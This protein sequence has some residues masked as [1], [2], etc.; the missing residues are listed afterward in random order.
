MADISDIAI[1]G[2]GPVG[3]ALALALR[4]SGLKVSLL[5]ARNAAEIN[6][7]PRA[8][9]LS[10]GSRLLLM[11]LGVWDALPDVSPIKAIHISQ[12]NSFGRTLLESAKLDVPELGYVLPYTAIQAA[13]Q[14]ALAQSRVDFQGGASVTLLNNTTHGADIVYQQA[15]VEKHLSAR[16]VVVADGGKTL[17]ASYPAEV[18]DYGQSAIIA[19]VTCSQPKPSTAYERFTTHGPL[20]L[21]PYKGGYEL[22]WTVPNTLVETML[23]WD[24]NTLLT[25]LHQHFGDRVGRFLSVGN[26]STFSLKLKRAPDTTLPHTVLIGNAAQTLHPVAGQGFNLGLRDAWVLAQTVLSSTPDNLGS[27]TMLADYKNAR[28]L[29]RNAGIRFTDGLVKLFSNDL[30]LLSTARAASLSLLDSLPG[31]KKFV[32]RHMM[33][34][35]NG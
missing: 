17:E 7:D 34:G 22:V 13:M 24:D 10:Y 11:R 18:H 28:K 27:A 14:T 2:G 23:Q 8:L 9:A 35:V 25:Q 5:E 26:R 21:L 12:K 30:T 31:M 33:F 16:L 3:A 29:D 6:P 4:D 32:A 20:A 15:G 1:I 19:H